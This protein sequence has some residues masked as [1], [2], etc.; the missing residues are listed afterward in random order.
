MTNA[1][2][3]MWKKFLII[4]T[5]D[6]TNW[7][8]VVWDKINLRVYDSSFKCQF[9]W[10]TTFINEAAIQKIATEQKETTF[11]ISANYS[12]CKTLEMDARLSE[13]WY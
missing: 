9:V 8:N 13:P 5:V 1:Q 10:S 7:T 4:R 3:N 12:V 11:K 6:Y 2:I